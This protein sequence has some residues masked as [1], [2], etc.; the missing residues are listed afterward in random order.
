MENQLIR[1]FIL[2]LLVFLLTS[3]IKDL[4]D[5]LS[6]TATVG[7]YLSNWRS[8]HQA[9]ARDN[10]PPPT[11]RSPTIK[12][13]QEKRSLTIKNNVG[14]TP[15][16]LNGLGEGG[17]A[18]GELPAKFFTP[19]ANGRRKLKSSERSIKIK[20]I[21]PDDIFASLSG[22]CFFNLYNLKIVFNLKTVFFR[23]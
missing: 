4:L 11:T 23:R 19:I 12:S 14:K 3:D 16:Q 21:N 22:S 7:P 6:T 18:E 2:I 20:R 5:A 9:H 15:D 8:Q 1:L 17:E 10:R 13:R